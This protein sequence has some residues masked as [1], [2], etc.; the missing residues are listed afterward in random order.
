MKRHEKPYGCTYPNCQKSFGSKNDWKRHES[1]QHFQLENWNCDVCS[2][3]CHRRETFKHHLKKDHGIE[4]RKEMEEKLERGRTGPKYESTRFWCGFCVQIIETNQKGLDAWKER[5]NHID[6]H[7]SGRKCKKDK[8]DWKSD[9][10]DLSDIPEGDVCVAGSDDG[11]GDAPSEAVGPNAA[12]IDKA[13]EAATPSDAPVHSRKRPGEEIRHS[14]KRPR[15][16]RSRLFWVCVSQS[17]RLFSS[18]ASDDLPV[19][20]QPRAA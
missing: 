1:S 19:R 3:V 6:D 5:Y 14:A 17:H 15:H 9:E 2:K 4:D 10:Q 11:D 18:T 7:L 16:E 8:S 20:V 12:A 13:D